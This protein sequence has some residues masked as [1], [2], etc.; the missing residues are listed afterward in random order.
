MPIEVSLHI[1][2]QKPPAGVDFGAQKGSGS[3]YETVQV[4]R[5][6]GQDLHFFLNAVVKG[7]GLKDPLPKFS[8]PF[9]QGPFPNN[10]IYIGIGAAA[11]QAVSWQR[12]LKIPLTGITWATI[13]QLKAAP[14]LVLETHVAG[15]AKDGTPNCATVKP[16]NRWTIAGAED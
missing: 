4:Q 9:I 10:F 16:F 6:H 15:T 13:D 14:E 2:L 5:S 11:G 7:D 3:V 8:G 1:V 12:R